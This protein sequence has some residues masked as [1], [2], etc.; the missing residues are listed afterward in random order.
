[1]WFKHLLRHLLRRAHTH[2]HIDESTWFMWK[3]EE[4]VTFFKLIH[5]SI[6]N[7]LFVCTGCCLQPLKSREK[8]LNFKS[9][10]VLWVLRKQSYICLG[11]TSTNDTL[12]SNVPPVAAQPFLPS[13]S[14]HLLWFWRYLHNMID[15]TYFCYILDKEFFF[16]SQRKC[17]LFLHSFSNWTNM[18]MQVLIFL[19]RNM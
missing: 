12:V 19:T 8:I 10:K 2:K 14:V 15:N 6:C 5:E 1:M 11:D 3:D 16:C 18:V 17:V 7:T 13:S 4:T 9:L